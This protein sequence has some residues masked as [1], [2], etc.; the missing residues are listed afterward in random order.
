MTSPFFT[1]IIPTYN[2]ASKLIIGLKSVLD[3]TFK[4]F[5]VVIIDDGSTDNTGNLI[6]TECEDTRISYFWQEGSK[7]PANPRNKGILK[8]RGSWIALLDSDDVW[9]P[10][11]LA[12]VYD[13]IQTQS[14]IDVICHN[15]RLCDNINN[16]FRHISHFNKAEYIF[17]NKY[18][19]NIY[20]NMLI[21]WNCLSPSATSI[22]KSFLI[23]NN[24]LFN[25]SPE[26]TIVED[27]DFWLSL[28]KN[29]AVFEFIDKTL[30][31]YVVD[32]ENIYG[33]WHRYINN[34][35]NLYE[36]HAF[37]VQNF[38]PVK[39]KIYKKLIAKIH[40]LRFKKALKEKKT[41]VAFKEIIQ[42]L[43]KYP[44]LL[45]SEIVSFASAKTGNRLN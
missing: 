18:S 44:T 27:Y 40:F 28:A 3:Q 17:R 38:E 21:G 12:I 36:H 4:D 9:Y 6:K 1:V 15:E 11:K 20:K 37:N 45:L 35:E 29:G 10:D 8:A 7:S 30:G 13:K 19:N 22:K 43:C 34:L 42:T 16:T 39:N 32:G 41:L 14:I 31:N 24:I 2:R 25:E 23:E 26:F 33:N 5:E